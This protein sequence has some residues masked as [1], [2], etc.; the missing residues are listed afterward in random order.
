[1][2]IVIYEGRERKLFLPGDCRKLSLYNSCKLEASMKPIRD[3]LQN[4]ANIM[5]P[6]MNQLI[7]QFRDIMAETNDNRREILKELS[8]S[9]KETMKEIEKRYPKNPDL[10]GKPPKV[11]KATRM[12]R[13]VSKRIYYHIRSNC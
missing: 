10:L 3:M 5:Q 8:G 12:N 7:I 4:I 11:I 1:M 13:K 2:L 6:F 9:I